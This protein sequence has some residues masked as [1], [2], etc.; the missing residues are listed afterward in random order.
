VDE[1]SRSLA[2]IVREEGLRIAVDQLV[3]FGHW[4]T[5]VGAPRRYDTRFFVAEAPHAQASLHDNR[6]TISHVW[7]HPGAALDQHRA[8][9]FKMR[10]PTVHTLERFAC[11]DN[12]ASLLGA[13]SSQGH[14]PAILPRISRDGRR[15]LPGEKGYEEAVGAGGQ[16]KW[17]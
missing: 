5:P 14:V 13:M 11:Y 1:G 10:T 4:I 9:G 6:E 3:Y 2:A 17:Q 15:L 8:G 12:V 16:G 7:I